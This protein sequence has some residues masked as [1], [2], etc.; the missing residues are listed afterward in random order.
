MPENE[1]PICHGTHWILDENNVAKRC[2]CFAKE[3]NDRKIR[4]AS[5]P[6]TYEHATIKNFITDIYLAPES[7]KAIRDVALRINAYMK[8]LDANLK[9]GIGLF[10][11]SETRGSGK[12][13]MAA[14]IANELMKNHSIKFSTSP[15]ILA[16][17]KK[18]WGNENGY[19]ESNLLSDLVTS[20]ILVID[21]FGTEEVK[22]WINEKFYY[23]VNERYINKRTTIYTSNTCIDNLPYD[24]RIID[25]IREQSFEIHFP[26]ESVRKNLARIREMQFE[27]KLKGE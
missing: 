21:D 27:R 24:E 14:S 12:T 7:K 11:W 16:E 8:D 13:R 17:I 15:T 19:S 23:I 9:S 2:S 25:R 18:T 6:S 26:E 4:F 5:I 10:L 22:G 1:C 20:E 3:L